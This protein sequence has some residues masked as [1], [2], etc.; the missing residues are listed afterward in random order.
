MSSKQSSSVAKIAEPFVCGGAAASFASIII[1]PIDLAKVGH[2][3][4]EQASCLPFS[5]FLKLT[6]VYPFDRWFRSECSY[7]DN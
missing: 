4:A 5:F 2:F 1:H 6:R 3:T 7:M